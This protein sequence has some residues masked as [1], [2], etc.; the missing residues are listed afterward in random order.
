MTPFGQQG[1]TCIESLPIIGIIAETEYW[2][3]V[4]GLRRRALP[5][6]GPGCCAASATVS[7]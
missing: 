5:S 6:L 3:A 7:G 4:R 1:C 2:I